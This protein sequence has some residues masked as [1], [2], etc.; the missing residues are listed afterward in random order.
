MFATST[1]GTIL[2]NLCN[3]TLFQYALS[4]P[5]QAV[6]LSVHAAFYDVISLCRG[7]SGR[8]GLVYNF[9][10]GYGSF[11]R[12][13]SSHFIGSDQFDMVVSTI[14]KSNAYVFSVGI[15]W[16]VVTFFLR[17]VLADF[18]FGGQPEPNA[19]FVRCMCAG[20]FVIPFML[21][22]TIVTSFFW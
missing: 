12:I 6:A 11:V 10:L 16:S 5:N 15:G 20:V 18:F 21:S 4:L 17:H 7:R 3:Q 19:V 9:G 1:V 2:G 13:L 8:N 22:L 14:R